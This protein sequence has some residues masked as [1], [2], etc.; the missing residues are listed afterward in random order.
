MGV[1]LEAAQKYV[2][3]T[4]IF[5]PDE[6]TEPIL[7]SDLMPFSQPG[8]HIAGSLPPY[9][10]GTTLNTSDQFKKTSLSAK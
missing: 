10:P 6:K 9:D 3:R 5:L 4:W 1:D 8:E 7:D 2:L